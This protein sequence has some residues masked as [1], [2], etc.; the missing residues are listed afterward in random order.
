ME[1]FVTNMDIVDNR[2]CDDYQTGILIVQT[3][4]AT[5][6]REL[7]VFRVNYYKWRLLP[8]GL[9]ESGAAYILPPAPPDPTTKTFKPWIF[10]T[11]L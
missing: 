9:M 5:N 1:R 3:D 4:R 11:K 7:F 6:T 8:G 10:R 2:L